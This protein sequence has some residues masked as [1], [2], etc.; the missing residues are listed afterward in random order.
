MD[1][2]NVGFLGG[3]GNIV[4]DLVAYSPQELVLNQLVDDGMLVGSRLGVLLSV[5]VEDLLVEE[6]FPEA[7]LGIFVTWSCWVV[8]ALRRITF[9]LLSLT[10]S[11]L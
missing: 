10:P 4:F 8:L 1:L 3:E 7:G 2:V 5:L 6:P 9:F 11:V